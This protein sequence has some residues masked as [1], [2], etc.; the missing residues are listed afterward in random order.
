M[1][2]VPIIRV[3]NTLIASVQE[4]LRDRD[5]L[6]M[7][8]EIGHMLERTGAS[9]VLVDL[10]V[11]QTLDSFLGRLLHD[12]ALHTALLGAPTV[13]VGMQPAVAVTLVEM[14]LGLRG[15]R[16]ALNVDRGLV[17]LRRLAGAQTGKRGPS[18]R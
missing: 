1:T 2:K 10:S 3:E 17:L 12:I 11:V 7:Q 14:G 9:G 6:E 16:T 13:V 8:S 5:A 15:I 18:G 4:G